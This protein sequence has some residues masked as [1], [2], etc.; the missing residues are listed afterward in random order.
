MAADAPRRRRIDRVTAD[1]YLDGLEERT[2]PEVRAMRDECRDE[3]SRLSY[4]RRLLHGQL[5]VARAELARRRGSG[6]ALLEALPSILA[7][8]P[9][10]GG[11]GPRSAGMADVYTPEGPQ[12][13]RRGDRVLD[14]MPLGRIPDLSDEDLAVVIARLEREEAQI[15]SLRRSVLEHLDALQAHLIERLRGGGSALDEIVSSVL[16]RPTD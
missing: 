7:D 1:D 5:D 13:R 2:A 10:G 8:D 9:P 16:G 15:S 4:A 12:G 3:E 6:G 11:R 14:E